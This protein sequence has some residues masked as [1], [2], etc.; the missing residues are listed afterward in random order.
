M[1]HA[2]ASRPARLFLLIVFASVL[3]G[4][5][6]FGKKQDPTETLPVEEMYAEAKKSLMN[7]NF[8]RAGRYYSRLISR[9]PFGPYTEQAQLE[10]AF[11]H[12]KVNNT[13]E[14]TSVLNR[15]I[16]TFPT[17]QHIDYAHYLKALINFNQENAFLER[18]ARLDMTQ[19]DQTATR[20]SFNDFAVLVQRYPNSRYAADSRQRM[21]HLRNIMARSE[22]GVG[23]YYLKRG[24]FVAAANRGQQIIED[25]PQSIHQNDA[26]ALMAEA[27]TRIGEDALADDARRVLELNQ[28]DHPWLSGNWPRKRSWWRSL[29]PFAGEKPRS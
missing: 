13:A 7:E 24:A 23:L 20:Q 4:C 21:V 25:Y 5:G 16:R 9:F 6:L 26:L 10:L 1:T 2:F 3:A 22:L 14:A 12:F 15:F 11:V 28:P 8:S 27:Y 17:H 19:R 29:I 18:F